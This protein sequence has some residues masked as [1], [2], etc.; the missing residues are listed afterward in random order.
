MAPNLT[1]IDLDGTL[2]HKYL[3]KLGWSLSARRVRDEDLYPK[4]E[5]ENFERLKDAGM[6][7]DRGLTLCFICRGK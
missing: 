3:V 5:E 1:L 6:P 7:F 2:N 4:T